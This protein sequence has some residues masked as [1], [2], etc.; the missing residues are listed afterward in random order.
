MR[1]LTLMHVSPFLI[2]C[3][4]LAIS[5]SGKSKGTRNL[6]FLEIPSLGINNFVDVSSNVIRLKIGF[7][8]ITGYEIMNVASFP[9]TECKASFAN[10]Y[11]WM[12]DTR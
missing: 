5:L 4:E 1:F 6:G 9:E 3:N 8:L 12:G 10:E 11:K 7:L 2:L